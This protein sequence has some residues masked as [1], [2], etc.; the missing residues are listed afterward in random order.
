[1][2]RSEAVYKRAIYLVSK[3]DFIKNVARIRK[4]AGIPPTGFKD[5]PSM[6]K[7]KATHVYNI[8]NP[9]I[10]ASIDAGVAKII[11]KKEY[12]LSASWRHAIKRYVYLNNVDDMQLPGGLQLRHAYDVQTGRPTIHV[13]VTEDVT[14]PDY[15]EQW[16]RIRAWQRRLKIEPMPV[17]RPADPTNLKRGKFAYDL[18]AAD[19]PYPDIARAIDAEFGEVCTADMAKTYVKN[20]MKQAGI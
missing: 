7:W 2:K 1:M 16:K 20:F 8:L 13:I 18:W 19:V 3:P 17:Q 10:E 4:L 6:E 11:N 9:K 14:E 15:Q 5:E 12:R